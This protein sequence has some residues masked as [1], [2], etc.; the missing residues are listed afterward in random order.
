MYCDKKQISGFSGGQ[1]DDE[2]KEEEITKG[3]KKL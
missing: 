2:I 3:T 1:E